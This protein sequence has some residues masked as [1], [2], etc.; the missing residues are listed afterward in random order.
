MGLTAEAEV[1]D[2]ENVEDI[3]TDDFYES[4]IKDNDNH[5][6]FFQ[7]YS[8]WS[9][10]QLLVEIKNNVWFP[11][12]LSDVKEEQQLLNLKC[13]STKRDYKKLFNKWMW[14]TFIK[15][16][17]NEYQSLVYMPD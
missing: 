8:Y 11:A 16:L 5:F 17:G 14:Q 9:P 10:E 1:V 13:P 6:K 3:T 2:S 15:G 12:K 7:K 4:I